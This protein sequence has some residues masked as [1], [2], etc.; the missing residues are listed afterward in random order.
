MPV[1]RLFPLSATCLVCALPLF[2]GCRLPD[3]A[4]DALTRLTPAELL[5][6][7]HYL[8]AA[9]I[10]APVV[11]ERPRDPDAAWM[12]SRAEA[13]LGKLAEAMSLAETALAI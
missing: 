1:R 5:D 9:Q 11:K 13:A 10:L 2:A 4:P 8:R 6:G 7:G 12:L 3:I